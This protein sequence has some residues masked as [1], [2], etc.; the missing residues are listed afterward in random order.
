MITHQLFDQRQ[1]KPK[2]VED[3][4]ESTDYTLKLKLDVN[5]GK[6][7][8]DFWPPNLASIFYQTSIKAFEE[9]RTIHSALIKP[10]QSI[11]GTIKLSEYETVIL[12][13]YLEK[14]QLSIIMVCTTI[15]CVTN[16][17]IPSDYLYV[18]KK[19]DSF[20]YFEI[21]TK[22]ALTIKLKEILP[23][24]IGLPFPSSEPFWGNFN[25]LVRLRN[26]LIHMKSKFT[27]TKYD[28]RQFFERHD[29]NLINDL[30][31]DKTINV[32]RSGFELIKFLH[33]NVQDKFDFPIVYASEPLNKEVV[34][35]ISDQYKSKA[36][37]KGRV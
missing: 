31:Q 7:N 36:P 25:K 37:S 33:V 30:I 8:L 5:Y 20:N 35:E 18:N 3:S 26:E 6:S 1:R 15:E 16:S 2:I 23:D 4:S 10:K 14:I 32:T 24:S 19:K 12:Y 27:N 34:K 11:R 13:D 22:I 21:Q 9:A 28:Q 17:I 29:N